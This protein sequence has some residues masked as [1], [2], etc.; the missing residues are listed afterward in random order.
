MEI[1]FIPSSIEVELFLEQPKPAKSYIPKW[2]KDIKVDNKLSFDEN[3]N[4]QNIGV[5]N[6]MPFFDGISHGYIQSTWHDIHIK[7]NDDGTIHYIGANS[8][9]FPQMISH[10]DKTTP[11]DFNNFYEKF[12]F[13]WIVQW[14]PKLPKGWSILIVPPLNHF[15]LPFTCTSGIID[16]D[17]FFHVKQGA[18]P[19]YFKK[20]FEGVIPAGTPMYQMIPIKRKNWYSKIIK[21]DELSWMKKNA[22]FY[23]SFTKAY[24]NKFWKRKE[25]N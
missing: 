3:N 2:Y 19:F 12:E 14:V 11:I 21:F 15:D 22:I 5:K 4:L 25:F 8:S 13:T 16:A 23:G 1:E 17:D 18:L 10:R 20:D 6:C 7:K 9:Q 24:K